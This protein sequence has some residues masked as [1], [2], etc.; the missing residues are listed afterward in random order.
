MICRR[1]L[2]NAAA[3]TITCFVLGACDQSEASSS[4]IEKAQIEL[5][6][7]NAF[8]AKFYLDRALEEGQP[9]RDL[10]IFFAE[11]ALIDGDL[12]TARDWLEQ[13][14]FP[15]DMQADRLQLLGRLEM[16][17]G[18][19]RGAARAF[20]R[21]YQIDPENAALWVDIGYLRYRGGEQIEAIEAV[22]HALE[23]D[24]T[25]GAAWLFRGQLARDA[26]G[27]ETGARIFRKALARQPA[28]TAL[29]VEYAATLGDAGRAKEALQVLRA[30]EGRAASTPK[31]LFLQSVIAARGGNIRLARD[32]FVRSEGPQK[33][34]PAAQ[35]LSAIIDLE[36]GNY[37]SAAQT[38]DRLS[39]VQPD[40]RRV[41]DLLAYALSR[42]GGEL[43]LVR[44]FAGS[45]AGSD[46]SAYL[47]ALVGRSYETLGER[48]LAAV[49]LDLASIDQS[50]LSVLAGARSVDV[51]AG[52][53][54]MDGLE[55]RDYVRNAIARDETTASV[56][57][58]R[59]FARRFPGSADAFAI[60]GDAELAEGN[61]RAARAAY[62]RSARI[63]RSWPLTLRL[64]RAQDSS[65]D[66]RRLLETFVQGDPMNGEAA[67]R[68]ADAAAAKGD[69]AK[70]VLLLDHAMELGMGQVPWV[71]AARSIAARQLDDPDTALQ[72]ALAAHELQPMSP[73]AI[74]ALI[75][76]LPADEAE[77]RE[78]LET[79]LESLTQG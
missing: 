21:S 46:G 77:T 41:R 39:A 36:E 29:R 25:S 54:P 78:E 60:L 69:W 68:L 34:S 14:E 66:A 56:G 40:N 38:L 64:V 43:E 26:Q 63:R 2:T 23:I 12:E 61:R 49:F 5:T 1:N 58:A 45:A 17:E 15:Y 57:R 73:L 31:G 50:D 18:D 28:N 35:L 47:R 59:G 53:G 70:A 19:L 74:S 52:S 3:L 22:D 67:A 62:E 30:G 13:E 76:A 4:S 42:S 51:L 20:D 79:K 27:A 8:S 24:P 37:A 32:L 72:F 75:A 16:M 33:S 10:A 65:T 71:L 44:R 6:N 9:R 55:T 48:E 11:A 7:G